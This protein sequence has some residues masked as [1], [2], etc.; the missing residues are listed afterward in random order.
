MTSPTTAATMAQNPGC[1]TTFT[2]ACS[3]MLCTTIEK[4][5]ALFTICITFCLETIP[6][7][8]AVFLGLAIVGGICVGLVSELIKACKAT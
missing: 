3:L 5:S 8:L 6:I 4:V 2:N 7:G 1:W